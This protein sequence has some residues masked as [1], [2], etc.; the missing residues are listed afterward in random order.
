[1]TH[2]DREKLIAQ[3][4]AGYEEVR[5]ALAGFPAGQLTARPLPGKWS[6]CEIVHHLADSEMR[7]AIRLRQLLTE[8]RPVIQ[9]Y[10]Q[11]AY[12]ARLN[13]NARDIAPALEAFRGAR[14]TTA[15]LLAQMSAEDWTREGMHPEH[16]RYTA[17]NWL[18]IYAAH[19]HN[20]AAQ[21]RRLRETLEAE[22]RG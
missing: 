1:M 6:A 3:Y 16:A 11:E 5:R 19:A 15:Q 18:E 12:A 10:D 20:H 8:D 14:S 13:Y 21:I 17:G 9:S 4:E 7:A 22:V 2:A